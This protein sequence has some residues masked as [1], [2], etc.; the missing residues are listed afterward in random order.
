ERMQYITIPAL[1]GRIIFVIL[2][3]VFI[4]EKSDSALFLFFMGLGNILASLFGIF[5]AFRI[6]KLKFIRPGWHDIKNNL[7][8]G[9]QITASN[10]SITTCQYIGV[11][12]LRLFTN[13]LLVGYYSIAEKIYQAMKL[14]VN[15]FTQVVYPQVCQIIQKGKGQV[16]SFLRQVYL[17]F[18]G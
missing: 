16:V 11:F 3:F 15:V 8:N 17:P 6:Y 7:K 4:K 1:C 12:I 5:L 9:W 14:M 18:L 2:T 13:D 10:L